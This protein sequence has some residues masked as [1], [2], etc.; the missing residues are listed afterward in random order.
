MTKATQQ[1]RLMKIA[2]SLFGTLAVLAIIVVS[3]NSQA[4]QTKPIKLPLLHPDA[5]IVDLKHGLDQDASKNIINEI[6][7]I[8][9][10][11][12][13]EFT[14]KTN[15]PELIFSIKQPDADTTIRIALRHDEIVQLKAPMT[16]G[17]FYCYLDIEK[18]PNLKALL[19]SE[20][21]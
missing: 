4:F 9:T 19:K 6:N 7:E 18:A 1:K 15:A 8:R 12:C 21:D 10:R 17:G 13:V 16:S 14:G 2:L 5:I 11:P 20:K 3:I